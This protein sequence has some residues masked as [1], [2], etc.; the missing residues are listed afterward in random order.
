[1]SFYL[2]VPEGAAHIQVACGRMYLISYIKVSE[3]IEFETNNFC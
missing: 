2:S 3:S 1:M